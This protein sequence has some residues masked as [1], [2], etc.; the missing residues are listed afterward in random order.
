MAKPKSK[1]EL[2]EAC[3]VNFKKLN[4]LIDSF[5][6]EELEKEFPEG[7]MNRNVRDVLAHLYH[8]SWMMSE[9]YRVGMTGAKPVMPAKGF[10]WKMMPELNQFIFEKY[11]MTNLEKARAML[12]ASHDEL[13][14]LIQSHTD[15]ELFEKKKY[16]WTGSTSLGV[17]L[18][19]NTS[20]HYAWAYKLIKKAKKD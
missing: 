4:D 7:T 5:S 15:E 13:Q 20:S 2:L 11:Q 18:I 8:W 14:I 17:Y 9:W 3:Q 6:K 16:H 1:V 12:Q 10:T 19:A